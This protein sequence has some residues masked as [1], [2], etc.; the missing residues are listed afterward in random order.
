MGDKVVW[1]VDVQP[2]RFVVTRSR[3]L[4]GTD[5]TLTMTRVGD[6]TPEEALVQAVTAFELG[7]RR[8]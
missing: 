7:G 4:M 8:G 1:S 5:F 3:P 2:T 6:T